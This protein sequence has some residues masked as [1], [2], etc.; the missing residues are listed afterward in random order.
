MSWLANLRTLLGNTDVRNEY[1]RWK[2]SKLLTG[3]PPSLPLPRGR[4]VFPAHRFNDYH[5]IARQR[6]DEAEFLL[7]KYLL[8]TGGGVFVDV[9]ANV[10][11]VSVLAASTGLVDRIVAFEPSHRYCSAWHMNTNANAIANATLIQAA[12]SDVTGEANFRADPAMPLHGRL[13]LGSLYATSRTMR[14]TTVTLDD[15]CKLFGI[16]QIALLKID[17][18]GAEAKVIRGASKL[19]EK[20]RIDA[21]VLEFIVEHIE[22]MGDDPQAMVGELVRAGFQI[23]EILPGGEVGACLDHRNVVDSRRVPPGAKERPFW[24]INLVARKH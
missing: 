10:G 15:A 17:V 23:Y 5:S 4:R 1:L 8:G 21:I 14:V 13:D 2:G 11:A 3:S 7:F 12:V 18:E 9:G 6:P 20:G 19:L 24:G 22:D 16:R